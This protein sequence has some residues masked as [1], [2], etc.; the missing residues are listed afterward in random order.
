[1]SIVVSSETPRNAVRQVLTLVLA[2]AQ[3]ITAALCFGLGTGFD[4]AT[5]S[6]VGDPPIIPAGYTFTIWALIYGGAIAYGAYQALP[7]RRADPLLRR[8]G[9]PAASAFLG[10]SA[11]LV[12]ARFGLI[13]LTV[14]C[15]VWMMASLVVV[16][17][18]FVLEGAPRT[19]EEQWFVVAPLSLFAG[20]VTAATFANTA[21]ALM[22]SGWMAPG[23]SETAWS[24]AMLVA[25]GVIGAWATLAMRGNA[26]YALAVVW[27]LGG[28]VVANTIERAE[29]RPVAATACVM[30]VLVAAAFTRARIRRP[31]SVA[32]A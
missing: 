3:P 13:W 30:A 12:M 26:A 4:E 11:W 19:A 29:N 8:I 17:H 28:I 5:R 15:I 1:M 21:A 16:L 10:T 18:R 27:A 24:V 20:Y 14:V 32:P 22:G 31:S 25:A 7:S 9:L 2:L 6:G 23:A